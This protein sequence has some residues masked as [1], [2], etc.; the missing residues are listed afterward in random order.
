[1]KYKWLFVTL[2]FYLILLPSLNIK[3][4]YAWERQEERGSAWQKMPIT[5]TVIS[6][7]RQVIVLEASIFNPDS[8]NKFCTIHLSAQFINPNSKIVTLKSNGTQVIKGTRAVSIVFDLSKKKTNSR[9][10]YRKDSFKLRLSCLKVSEDET[11]KKVP[12]PSQFCNPAIKDCDQLCPSASNNAK[13]CEL[14][15]KRILFLKKET[16]AGSIDENRMGVKLKIK[17][18]NNKIIICDLLL[19]ILTTSPQGDT[20]RIDYILEEQNIPPDVDYIIAKAVFKKE[21]PQFFEIKPNETELLATCR[22]EDEP[23]TEHSQ[24]VDCNPELR[25]ECNWVEQN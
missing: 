13:E 8:F 14:S 7:P 19:K 24:M 16:Q 22:T 2:F 12:S 20:Y 17:N 9:S 25:A 6:D 10:V 18:K 15:S 3:N 4:A 1:M 21:I 5:Y 11:I 23:R